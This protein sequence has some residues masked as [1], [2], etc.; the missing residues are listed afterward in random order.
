MA[1]SGAAHR[2]A[3]IAAGGETPD[4]PFLW[5][6]GGEG[7]LVLEDDQGNEQLVEGEELAR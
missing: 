7:G 4:C 5:P 6:C 2:F 1:G 3:A